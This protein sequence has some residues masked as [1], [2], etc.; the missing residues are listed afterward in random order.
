LLRY[1][2]IGSQSRKL[3]YITPYD[4]VNEEWCIGKDLEGGSVA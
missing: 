4:G 1:V 2:Y 3:L